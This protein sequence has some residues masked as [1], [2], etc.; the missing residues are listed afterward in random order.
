MRTSRWGGEEEARRR[1]EEAR[2]SRHPSRH[3]GGTERRCLGRRPR[4]DEAAM[5]GDDDGNTGFK[6][7]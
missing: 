7:R 1:R 5:L 4:G 3:T 6:L 2:L